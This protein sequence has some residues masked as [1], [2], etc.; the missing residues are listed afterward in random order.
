MT[1]KRPQGL[2]V[3]GTNTGV[4]KTFVAAELA[5]SL[6][7]RGLRVGVYKPVLSG[8]QTES[9]GT[10]EI[11][12]LP[13]DTQEDAFQADDDVYLWRAA[14]CPGELSQVCP[15]R[16]RAPLAPHLAA[17]SE[18][19]VVNSQLLRTGVQ[20]WIESSDVV[21]V[22][23]AGGLFS[24]IS[25]TELNADL[26]TDFG[27]PVLLVATNTLG[28]IHSTLAT[29]F[30]ARNYRDGLKI[31]AVYLNDLPGNGSDP[32]RT[33][34]FEQLERLCA[35]CPVVRRGSEDRLITSLCAEGATR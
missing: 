7:A 20:P 33:S 19:R 4:G 25:D 28:V 8:Y 18:G 15:Q 2:F 32:S 30:A 29:L 34:N 16:F 21:L 9:L 27:W 23:G 1:G 22:E 26:A 17:R 5:R 24:P 11:G 35:P 12:N 13:I 6:L 10:R 14:G 3:S 31:V